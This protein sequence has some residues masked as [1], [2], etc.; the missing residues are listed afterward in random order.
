MS[1]TVG[2]DF[3]TH[4]TKVCIENASNPL[5]KI[6][7]FLEFKDLDGNQTCL[8]PSLIQVNKDDTLSYGFAIE[9]Q[10]KLSTP[11][12][13]APVFEE[14]IIYDIEEAPKNPDSFD[15]PEVIKTLKD[16]Y[17][18]TG[19]KSLKRKLNKA[20]NNWTREVKKLKKLYLQQ[21]KEFRDNER[22]I[23]ATKEALDAKI[24]EEKETYEDELRK[25]ENSPRSRM[26]FR[27]FKLASFGDCLNA[28]NTWKHEI[29][30]DLLSVWYLCYLILTL[31]KKLETQ[32]SIQIG[33]PSGTKKEILDCQKKKAYELLVSAYELSEKYQ[34]LSA[35]KSEK[36]SRLKDKTEIKM[37]LCQEDIVAYGIMALPEAFAGLRSVV[38]GNR[39]SKG[40]N[41][42]VDIGGGTT[43]VAF[44]TINNAI[45]EI[46]TVNSFPIG[47]NYIFENLIKHGGSYEE[48]HSSFLK[49]DHENYI[50]SIGVYHTKLK[51]EVNKI[52]SGLFESFNSTSSAHSL[53]VTRLKQALIDRPIV[54][55]GG[56]SVYERVRMQFNYFNQEKIINKELLDIN[57]LTNKH[58]EDKL[59]T[60]LATS[61]GL[62]L[63]T[64]DEIEIIPLGNLFDHIN[65]PA[66]DTD[67]PFEHGL[68]DY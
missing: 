36:I 44:F 61:Y 39:I 56:G 43:D 10:C 23:K 30:P 25:W 2:L 60:I 29:D 12:P 8:L 65:A 68:T 34:S 13:K 17:D 6:Y 11:K 32:Y 21:L 1:Y 62:C 9:E 40:M 67:Q 54:Y 55:C 14:Q 38:A 51:T 31:N 28:K 19:D 52:L 41:L 58:V 22:N 57:N 46:H 24:L 53:D 64:A 5:Q 47:L 63:P 37:N 33:I 3:G 49:N 16:R 18:K 59:Y 27:Y 66:Q 45:P 15:L 7:E 50:E 4:Q 20:K 42:L 35:F 26:H 48:I